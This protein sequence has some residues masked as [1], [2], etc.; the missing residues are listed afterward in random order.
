MFTMRYMAIFLI[1]A[2]VAACAKPVALQYAHEQPT[3]NEG[4][5]YVLV[6]EPVVDVRGG[7]REIDEAL[8]ERPCSAL[9]AI[10]EEE[11]R[12]TGL[13]AN[14]VRSTD[15]PKTAA[16]QGEPGKKHL[17]MKASLI[18]LAWDVPGYQSIVTTRAVTSQFGAVGMLARGLYESSEDVPVYGRTTIGVE[19]LD[20]DNEQVLLANEY[21]GVAQKRHKIE[22]CDK[23]ET[24]S[25]IIG[26]SAENAM[27]QLK[28]DVATL[29]ARSNAGQTL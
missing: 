24:K 8:T 21:Y 22:D 6:V 1:L 3:L 9:T 11:M 4:S 18:D 7:D 28:A 19:F 15:T 17:R 20:A 25:R 26:V 14:V 12:S 13:F 2:V 27:D 10:L 23:N 5:K 29:I 16:L